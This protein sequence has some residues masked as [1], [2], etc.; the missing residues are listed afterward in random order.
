M[1]MEQ[2]G[3]NGSL[4]YILHKAGREGEEEHE[5]KH[6][7]EEKL[8]NEKSVFFS[9]LADKITPMNKKDKASKSHRLEKISNTNLLVA[10]VT[11]TVAFTLPGGYRL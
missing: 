7:N 9:H 8:V 5:E 10:T 6:A 2:Q 1:R 11:F 3:G 4:Q